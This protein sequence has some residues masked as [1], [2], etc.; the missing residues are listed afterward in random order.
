MFGS[1]GINR[2]RYENDGALVLGLTGRLV[3]LL[4]SVAP[5]SS[6]GVIIRIELAYYSCQPEREPP[7]YF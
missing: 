5:V 6:Q 4:A 3:G 2:R 7:V 1:R